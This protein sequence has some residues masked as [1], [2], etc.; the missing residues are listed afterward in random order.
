MNPRIFPALTLICTSLVSCNKTSRVDGSTDEKM[1]ASIEEMRQGLTDSQKEQLAKDMMAVA[2]KDVNIFQ[3]SQAPELVQQQM[4]DRLNGK[5]R[6]E[7]Q[8]MADDVRKKFAENEERQRKELEA[9]QQEQLTKQIAQIQGEVDELMQAKAKATADAEALKKFEILRSRFSFEE[10]RFS[11]DA[12][13]EIS[14]RNQ[15][16]F[17]ISQVEF[18]GV[19][20]SP[21]RSVP[22]VKDKFS[23]KIA[24]GLEPGE[25]TT[26]RLAPNRF[27]EWSRAP[28]DRKDCVLTVKV[29]KLDGPDGKLLLD[30]EFPESKAQRLEQ[31]EASLKGLRITH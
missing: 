28:K 16:S 31:L 9:S 18:E 5:S 23:Y 19:L 27:G 24:G 14:V 1:K 21:G 20:T 22:W 12:T 17:P 6:Q 3:A 13:I 8:Q 4:R 7:I 30:S 26:W 11:T 25:E 29:L 15:T 2:F 10:N